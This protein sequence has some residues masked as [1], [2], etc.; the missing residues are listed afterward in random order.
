MI[1]IFEKYIHE[2]ARK[3]GEFIEFSLATLFVLYEPRV[4]L[5][6]LS[7][8]NSVTRPKGLAGLAGPIPWPPRTPDFTACNLYLWEMPQSLRE[9]ISQGV[10]NVDDESSCGVQ[11]RSWN[12]VLTLAE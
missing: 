9:G 8:E 7:E 4:A 5:R 1:S 12:V 10:A 3:Q 6:S 11:G 2:T